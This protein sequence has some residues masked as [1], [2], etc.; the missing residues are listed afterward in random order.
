[1]LPVISSK[2]ERVFI[3]ISEVSILYS[4]PFISL[5]DSHGECYT[6]GVYG[7]G[8]NAKVLERYIPGMVG[9]CMIYT[10]PTRFHEGQG[11]RGVSG[12]TPAH[13]DLVGGKN[14]NLRLNCSSAHSIACH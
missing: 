10:F 7:L 9:G 6:G 4:V 13:V 1:M 2:R 5:P 8:V 12:F 11:L 14:T 3:L